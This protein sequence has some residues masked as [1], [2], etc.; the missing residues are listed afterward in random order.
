MAEPSVRSLVVFALLVLVTPVA[1]AASSPVFDHPA[2]AATGS[3]G[4]DLV[5]CTELAPT[6]GGL[7][8]TCPPAIRPGAR[9][10][11]PAGCTMN[12]VVTD[13]IDHFIGTAAHC[14]APDDIVH[15]AGVGR[16]GR[17]ALEGPNGDWAFVRIDADKLG[18]VDPTMCRFGGP[19]AGLDGKTVREPLPGDVLLHYGHGWVAGSQ[20]PTRG[21]AAATVLP[22]AFYGHEFVFLG[23]AAGGD[24]GSPVRFATGEAAGIL[25]GILAPGPDVTQAA[26]VVTVATKFGHAMADLSAFLGREVT[27]VL[28]EPPLP[29]AASAGGVTLAD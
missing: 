25:V 5:P 29:V 27:V 10:T 7:A 15:V 23:S 17:V 13:G 12:F 26:A 20:E 19:H 4:A 21:R 2:V 18:L 24:S 1:M 9:M 22:W 28:G 11:S 8:I 3:L 16:I 14:V 6:D